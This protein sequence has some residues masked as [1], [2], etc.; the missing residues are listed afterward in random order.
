MFFSLVEH[1]R[2]CVCVPRVLHAVVV[3]RAQRRAARPLYFYFL[4]WF[5]CGVHGLLATK[6]LVFYRVGCGESSSLWG[7]LLR[8]RRQEGGAAISCPSLGDNYY[9]TTREHP[10]VSRMRMFC[11]GCVFAGALCARVCLPVVL[12]PSQIIPRR[13]LSCCEKSHLLLVAIAPIQIVFV[14]CFV[15]FTCTVSPL[16]TGQGAFF[17]CASYSVMA[18]R[19]LGD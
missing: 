4:S 6:V 3:D 9:N 7:V 14:F 17:F 18:Y 1:A 13:A 15:F 19:S 2:L 12:R 11:G 10:V 8:F 5:P 16:H